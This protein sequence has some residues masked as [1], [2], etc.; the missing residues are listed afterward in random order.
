[1]PIERTRDLDQWNA[2]RKLLR[3]EPF[4]GKQSFTVRLECFVRSQN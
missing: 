3:K 2:V 1:M 4:K